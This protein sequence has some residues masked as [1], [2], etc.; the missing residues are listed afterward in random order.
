MTIKDNVKEMGMYDLLGNCVYIRDNETWY[1]DFEIDMPLREFFRGL[2]KKHGVYE[3]YCKDD[4]MFDEMM[5]ENRMYGY[6]CIEGILAYWYGNL[7]A[8]AEYREE[9]KGVKRCKQ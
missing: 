5:V 3:D 9:I 7:V 2:M 6:G 8:L 4:D 1:R